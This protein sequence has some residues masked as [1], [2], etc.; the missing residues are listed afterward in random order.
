MRQVGRERYGTASAVTSRDVPVPEP[1]AG[2]VRIRV[3]GSSVNKGDRLVMAGTPYVMRLALGLRAPR[4]FGIGQD[5]AGVV[6]AVGE[7]VT[8]WKMGDAVF[9]ELTLGAAWA[10][11]VVAEANKLARAPKNVSLSESGALPVAALTAWQAVRDEG[12]IKPGDRV[13]VNG[14]SGSVGSYVVQLAKAVGAHVTAVVRAHHAERARTLGAD[15]V[16]D[17]DSEDFTTTHTPYDACIDV[18]GNVPMTRALRAVK[19]KGTYVVVG[20]PTDDPWLWP[21]LRPLLW[22]IR[23]VFSS[24]RVAVF[25]AKPTPERLAELSEWVEAGRVTPLFDSRCTLDELPQALAELEAG[26]RHGKV[27]VEVNRSRVGSGHS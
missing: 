21:L 6:S 20:G 19:P 25:I 27:L 10:D 12:R 3:H 1:G 14:G 5:V 15:T 24:R 4:G 16:V 11:E 26:D 17:A 23:G 13:V 9:G 7:G 18:A 2:E 8:K 22:I